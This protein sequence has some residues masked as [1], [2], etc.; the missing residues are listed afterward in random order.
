VEPSE[1]SIEGKPQKSKQRS[2]I[3]PPAGNAPSPN[4]QIAKTPF[5]FT[6]RSLLQLAWGMTLNLSHEAQQQEL[7]GLFG[8]QLAKIISTSE[9]DAVNG[10]FIRNLMMV[11]CGS[12]RNLAVI[13]ES[14]QGFLVQESNKLSRSEQ[15]TANARAENESNS[16]ES[17][18]RIV[19]GF[20]TAGGSSFVQYVI[21]LKLIVVFYWTLFG[22]FVILGAFLQPWGARIVKKWLDELRRRRTERRVSREERW[23]WIVYK[24]FYANELYNFYESTSKLIDR[25]YSH[26]DAAT[27]KGEDELLSIN[28]PTINHNLSRND[29]LC[30]ICDDII[31]NAGFHKNNQKTTMKPLK[32]KHKTTKND[33]FLE[34]I[35]RLG[36]M[37]N[38]VVKKIRR[39]I[40]PPNV[41]WYPTRPETNPQASV[42]P[43][44]SAS[45]AVSKPD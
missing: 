5:P 38:E 12:L 43:I 13:R 40:L 9:S 37:E 8:D 39:E 4:P 15:G 2:P 33:E 34:L 21:G 14:H 42:K 22:A 6:M 24:Q 23:V 10:D 3:R 16:R 45:T 29:E 7:G 28:Y 19:V 30:E 17:A 1:E 18:T 11:F 20:L 44:K 36:C 32:A 35:S 31:S 26:K 25:F 41:P 27:I